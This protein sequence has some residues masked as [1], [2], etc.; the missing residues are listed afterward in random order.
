MKRRELVAGVGS[1]GVVAAG[2]AVAW[3]GLPSIGDGGT[4]TDEG[5]GTTT[6]EDGPIVVETFDAPGSE[7]GTVPVPDE[8]RVT[9]IS[10]FATGCG[11]C[12]AQMPRLADARERTDAD[13]VRFLSVTSQ[14]VGENLSAERLREWWTD[15]GGDW[16]VG[17]D[18]DYALSRRYGVVGYPITI[19][20]D[21]RGE[22]RWRAGPAAHDSDEI[23]DGVESVLEDSDGGDD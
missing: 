14:H 22:E 10:S 19:V 6:D 15:L 7:S 16:Y 20:V 4:T 3:R 11:N 2:G 8:R 13:D 17:H 9:L 5:A 23:V 21:D 18:P 1:L 12:R